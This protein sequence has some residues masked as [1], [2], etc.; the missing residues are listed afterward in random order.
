[1]PQGFLRPRTS[2]AV[3]NCNSFDTQLGN[4]RATLNTVPSCTVS[5]TTCRDPDNRLGEFKARVIRSGTS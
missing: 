1:V 2:E 5:T 3:R 4:Y